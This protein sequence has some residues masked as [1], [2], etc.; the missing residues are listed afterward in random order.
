MGFVGKLFAI[1]MFPL[2]IIIVLEELGIYS[3]ALPIPVD[4]VVIG[5]ALMVLLQILTII[6][7]H[8]DTGGSS[9]MN[10]V[11]A[12][13]FIGSAV[14]AYFS[15]MLGF[16]PKESHIILGVMMFVEALYAL[17]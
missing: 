9:F 12:I 7:L 16:Y 2:S 6:M 13:I 15:G 4:K 3:V 10:Y 11:T 17:H 1:F 5:A 14:G 8:T